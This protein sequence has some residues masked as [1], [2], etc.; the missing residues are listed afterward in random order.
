MSTERR[1]P[2]GE[3][4]ERKRAAIVQTARRVF[5]REG[6]GVG[7]EQI[8]AEA[9][10]S[11]VTVYNHYGRKEDLFTAV[12]GDALE[13][14]LA[15]AQSRTEEC[16]RSGDDLEEVLVETARA[17]IRGM[18]TPEFLALRTLVGAELRRFPELGRAW[19]VNGPGRF[20]SIMAVVLQR[21]VDR[22]V[23][24]IANIEL[25]ITQLYSLVLYPHFAHSTYGDTIDQ[26]TTDQLITDGVAMF[27][28]FY[29]AGSPT[30]SA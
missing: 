6:F 29:R 5:L 14:A 3:R 25:A 22:G 27:L 17:W 19:K 1:P 20:R 26:A 30:P 12:I 10:V 28:H 2:S 7:M 23:L 8:A 13:D 24:A 11:K 15:D 21:E 16:L 4:A 9:G 18:A